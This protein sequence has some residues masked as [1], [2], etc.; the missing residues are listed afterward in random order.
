MTLASTASVVMS[1]YGVGDNSS[2]AVASKTLDSLY[3]MQLSQ[4]YFKTEIL[5]LHLDTACNLS[6]SIDE[7]AL[8]VSLITL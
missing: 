5:Y 6:V 4:Q 2:N 1:I 7:N 8:S 3:S